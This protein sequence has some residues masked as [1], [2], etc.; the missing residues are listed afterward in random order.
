MEE[1]LTRRALLASTLAPCQSSTLTHKSGE[2]ENFC[3]YCSTP[4]NKRL[5]VKTC[6]IMITLLLEF[7]PSVDMCLKDFCRSASLSTSKLSVYSVGQ[8]DKQVA[9]RS[10]LLLCLLIGSLSLISAA[11]ARESRFKTFQP[12]VPGQPPYPIWPFQFTA[13]YDVLVPAYVCI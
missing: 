12:Q 13:E 4:L 5:S 6:N 11:E 10:I 3:E 9:M 8:S 7:V 2:N 1:K